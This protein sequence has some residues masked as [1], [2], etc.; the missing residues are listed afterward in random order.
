MECR[1]CDL[2]EKVDGGSQLEP[3]CLLKDSLLESSSSNPGHKSLFDTTRDD[4]RIYDAKCMKRSHPWRVNIKCTSNLQ[5]LFTAVEKQIGGVERDRELGFKSSY[6]N[7]QKQIYSLRITPEAEHNEGNML[8]FLNNVPSDGIC[9]GWYRASEKQKE[10][11]TISKYKHHRIIPCCL[12][13][14]KRERERTWSG[15]LDSWWQMR[16]R[17]TL[18]L[19]DSRVGHIRQSNSANLS[20]H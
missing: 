20:L 5:I 18:K 2:F 15:K 7:H 16:L 14:N 3:R 9:R 6:E 17:F 4:N 8:W 19:F 10:E 1:K 13:N 11:K 12:F